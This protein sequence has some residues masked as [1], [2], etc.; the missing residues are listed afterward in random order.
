MADKEREQ[1]EN[2][3]FQRGHRELKLGTINEI[4]IKWWDRLDLLDQDC[5]YIDWLFPVKHKT[6]LVNDEVQSYEV[7]NAEL[8]V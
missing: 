1:Y 6:E 3:E 4:H 8:D 5:G 2:I 7:T